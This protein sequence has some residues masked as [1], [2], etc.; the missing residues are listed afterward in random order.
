MTNRLKRAPAA[1]PMPL[2]QSSNETLTVSLVIPVYNGG[3]NF[4]KCVASVKALLPPPAEVIVVG[5]GDDDGSSQLA[6]E[7]GLTVLRFPFPGGPAR[8][9]NLGAA[10]ATG[11]IVFFVDAD[12]TVPSDAVGQVATLFQREPDIAALFGSYDDNP[13]EATFLS[14]YRNLLHH[15]V[16]QHAREDAATFWGACGA[17][18]R[19]IFLALGGFDETYAKPS[20]E[21]IELGYR[22]KQAGYSIRLCK[23]LQ[24]KH[25]KRWEPGSMLRADFFQR[26]LPWT[27]LILRDRQCI[28]DL[29]TGMSGRASLVLMASM[30]CSL[31]AAP[32]HPRALALTSAAAVA[33]LVLNVPL[34]RFFLRKRGFGFMLR[35]IPWHWLYFIYSGTAFAIGLVRHLSRRAASAPPPRSAVRDSSAGSEVDR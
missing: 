31:V 8:A 14:Q 22:L 12:V 13:G 18:R 23:R 35:V 28:N 10:R 9:R 5:D 3:E 7:Q 30:L 32:W 19:D 27:D 34:Y 2:L 26:A 4:L 16:H 33:L 20:I 15:Y 25:W 17:I 11:Q 21:D 6:E 29:N 1:P 24:V